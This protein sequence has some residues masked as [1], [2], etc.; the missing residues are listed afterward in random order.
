VG[1]VVPLTP[2]TKFVLGWENPSKFLFF[3]FFFFS[4]NNNNLLSFLKN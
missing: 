1:C 2:E 4:K 3:F